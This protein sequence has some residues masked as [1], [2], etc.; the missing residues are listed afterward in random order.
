MTFGSESKQD[1][2]KIRWKKTPNRVPR[3]SLYSNYLALFVCSVP[4]I[5]LFAAHKKEL[6][7]VKLGAWVKRK[8]R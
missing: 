1:K 6:R 3:P 5:R 7:L 4:A 2:V 8:R